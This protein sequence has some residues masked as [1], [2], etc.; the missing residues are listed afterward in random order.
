[1]YKPQHSR[2]SEDRFDKHGGSHGNFLQL[3]T[4]S[5]ETVDKVVEATTAY[6]GDWSR[7]DAAFCWSGRWRRRTGW[8][9]ISPES[10]MHLKPLLYAGE[11]ALLN[12]LTEYLLIGF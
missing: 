10:D 1:M 8:R 3:A 5:Q 7:P 9:S 12:N 11:G 6:V 4:A 2:S